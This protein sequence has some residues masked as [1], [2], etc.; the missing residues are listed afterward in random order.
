LA[1]E[2]LIRLKARTIH[3]SDQ[4]PATQS[5][6]RSLRPGRSHL[7]IQ[8]EEGGAAAARRLARNGWRIV[9][10]IPDQTLVVAAENGLDPAES[11]I[12]WVGP[13]AA[14]DKLSAELET[15]EVIAYLV[16]FHPD[17]SNEDARRIVELQGFEVWE[18]P[19]LLPSELLVAAPYERIAG[20]S[21]WDEVAY[22]V[23]A[24]H[25]LISGSRVIAC[26]G[27]LTESGPVGQYVK[28]GKGWP[29]SNNRADLRYVI[30]SITTKMDESTVRSELSRAL[31]E[32]AKYAN[33]DFRSGM[34]ASAPGTIAIRFA[35]AS[36][37]DQYPFDGAGK[38]L[39]H[40]FY[41]SPPNSEPVAG[42]MHL[43]ADE[44]WRVGAGIDLFSVA[45][46]EAGHALGLGHSDRPGSVMYPYYRQVTGLASDDIAGI[47]DLYGE[48]DPVVPSPEPHNPSATPSTPTPST[49]TGPPPSTPPPG[50]PS[51][52]P[53]QPPPAS[54][55]PAEPP[56]PDSVS[57]GLRITSPGFTIV[58]A[59]SAAI[60]MRGTATDD[61]Q[62]V[63]VKWS[64]KSGA[65]GVAAGTRDWVAPDIPLLL[66]TNV[67]TIRA[68]DAAGN[69]SWRTVTVVRR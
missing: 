61:R 38:V 20:L 8:L 14:S 56:S 34:D 29:R 10:S 44:D 53:I 33:L 50:Q 3:P 67:V 68:Y 30:S 47:Q 16:M 31:D 23:P 17:V 24:S 69:S 46:H 51:N 12:R 1:A 66:G 58:T 28:V 19:D 45:L 43:D 65:T 15:S 25:D 27:A 54:P 9:G 22:I 13:L 18:H 2:P 6:A 48:R 57:P 55:P 36:H 32:W 62:V 63:A 4:A 60:T 26:A 37:G 41:P 5:R 64:T 42:D 52:P 11:G 7:L 40:T 59:F 21:E 35:A 39:A 49:P